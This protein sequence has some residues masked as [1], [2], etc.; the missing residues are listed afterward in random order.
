M[1]KGTTALLISLL[2]LGA[3]GV[4]GCVEEEGPPE[5]FTPTSLTI[6]FNEG[7]GSIHTGNLT[8]WNCVDG[9]WEVTSVD[10]GGETTYL[11]LNLSAD[12]CL[13]QLEYAADVAGFEIDKSSFSVPGGW[14]VEGID[15]LETEVPGP[16]WQFWVNGGY[17]DHSADQIDL[18]EG[19]EVEWRYQLSA[20]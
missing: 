8:T 1:V 10:G 13:G 3:V 12:N 2:L 7:G 4:T 11:F 15:G 6:H 20:F 14:L 5:T 9:K 19:D 18:V 17:S 16:A